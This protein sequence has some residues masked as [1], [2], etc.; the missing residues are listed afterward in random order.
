MSEMKKTIL[1]AAFFGI[2]L[3][4]TIFFSSPSV[5]QSP[6]LMLQNSVLPSAKTEAGAV[7]EKQSDWPIAIA[8]LIGGLVGF[9]AF[10]I[11][12]RRY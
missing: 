8:F 11:A 7:P 1:A 3:G 2:L 5:A 12:N 9:S 6:R 10:L 4:A